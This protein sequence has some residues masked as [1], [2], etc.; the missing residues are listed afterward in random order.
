MESK[1]VKCIHCD[2][3]NFPDA[4][5]CRS[6]GED[7]EPHRQLQEIEEEIHMREKILQE[8]GVYDEDVQDAHESQKS[9]NGGCASVILLIISISGIVSLIV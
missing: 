3:W 4:K 7:L 9:N 8:W 5:F 2:T 1:P 6:C